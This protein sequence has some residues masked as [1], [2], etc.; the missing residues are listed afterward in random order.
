MSKLQRLIPSKGSS[1]RADADGPYIR[2][3][4]H[5]DELARIEAANI[6]MRAALRT[7]PLD[8][9]YERQQA[10]LERLRAENQQLR[11]QLLAYG[12]IIAARKQPGPSGGRSQ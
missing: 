11:A 7:A 5:V 3:I 8:P 4:D 12:K 10:E 2:F 6:H 9:A 1:M